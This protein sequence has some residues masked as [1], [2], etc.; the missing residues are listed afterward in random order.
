[1]IDHT[2]NIVMKNFQPLPFIFSEII[3]ELRTQPA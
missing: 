3:E 1:M 2:L